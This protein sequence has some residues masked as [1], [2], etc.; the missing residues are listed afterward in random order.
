[1]Y[2]WDGYQWAN[3]GSNSKRW[4]KIVNVFP[5]LP[6]VNSRLW[7]W[8]SHSFS[9]KGDF[10][11]LTKERKESRLLPV[12]TEGT[13]IQD[14]DAHGWL[15]QEGEELAE[16]YPKIV[17]V[18]RPAPRQQLKRWDRNKK[19]RGWSSMHPPLPVCPQRGWPGMHPL[20]SPERLA[21]NAPMLASSVALLLLCVNMWPDSKFSPFSFQVPPFPNIFWKK[22]FLWLS[23][24]LKHYNRLNQLIKL[25]T[26]TLSKDIHSL[27]TKMLFWTQVLGEL[28][29]KFHNCGCLVSG[30]YKGTRHYFR[31]MFSGRTT[32]FSWLWV[33][34]W[35]TLE[36]TR[37]VA[38]TATCYKLESAQ[39]MGDL[40]A[41]SVLAI[42]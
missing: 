26:E 6:V 21:Q 3:V 15:L 42:K 33:S 13:E 1:M 19:W 10:L 32:M 16:K 2:Q 36:K 11:N 8:L 18:R 40:S 4:G 25:S 27:A 24:F 28:H 34:G 41:R 5:H 12:D 30:T 7:P 35:S 20:V 31:T 14:G 22:L 9:E 39:R 38:L 17:V 23:L 29:E 37:I